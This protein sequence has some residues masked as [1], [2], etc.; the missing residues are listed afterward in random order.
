MDKKRFYGSILVFMC[1]LLVYFFVV[2][3][4]FETG[5]TSMNK[6]DDFD[7]ID[8][9]FWYVGSMTDN[10]ELHGFAEFYKGILT[11]RKTSSGEDLYLLSKPIPVDKKQILTVKRRLKIKPGAEYFSGGLV[12][13]QTNSKTRILDQS[14]KNPF[15]SAIGIIEY[16]YDPSNKSTR[17]GNKNIRILS[18]DW[19]KSGFYELIE[20]VYNKWFEE[21]LTYNCYTGEMEYFIDNKEVHKIQSPVILDSS[22]RIWMHAYGNSKTQQIEVDKVEISLENIEEKALKKNEYESEEN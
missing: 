21:T 12:L 18:P 3:P 1:F 6:I 4:M 22:I 17:P 10:R 11:L 9:E 7:V 2:K 15:G 14:Q 16:V 8:N 13:F 19:K 5:D 20:P